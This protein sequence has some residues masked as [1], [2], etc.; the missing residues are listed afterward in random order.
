MNRTEQLER[1]MA[2][3]NMIINRLHA[4]KA[5]VKAYGFDNRINLETAWRDFWSAADTFDYVVCYGTGLGP[6]EDECRRALDNVRG[7]LGSVS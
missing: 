4:A 2:N 3:R 7:V 1:F 6:W 5:T